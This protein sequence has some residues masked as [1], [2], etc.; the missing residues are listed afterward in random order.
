MNNKQKRKTFFVTAKIEVVY[1]VFAENE[2][3]ALDRFEEALDD[4]GERQ[5][6]FENASSLYDIVKVE[7]ADTHLENN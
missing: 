1:E 4:E 3:A 2:E 6:I 7:D 5:S